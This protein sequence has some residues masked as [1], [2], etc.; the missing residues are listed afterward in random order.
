[1]ALETPPERDPRLQRPREWMPCSEGGLSAGRRGPTRSAGV[2]RA[3]P[4]GKPSDRANRSPPLGGFR[5]A[6]R[7]H[8]PLGTRRGDPAPWRGKP[9]S[10]DK[11]PL[12][13]F[14]FSGPAV[15]RLHRRRSPPRTARYRDRCWRHSAATRSR[16][17][18][19]RGVVV[20][21]DALGLIFWV[22][23]WDPV[24]P[25][26]LNRRLVPPRSGRGRYAYRITR[27]GER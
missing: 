7:P 13:S 5:F 19:R 27:F 10:R 6:E 8:H 25:Q 24:L 11:R 23:G 16:R 21:S 26:P 1:M 4:P 2:A 20:S 15:R 22:V 3:I 9:R 12:A 18:R 17:S 14:V